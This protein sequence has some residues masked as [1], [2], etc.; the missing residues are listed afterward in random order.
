MLGDAVDAETA[1]RWGMIWQAVDDAA[2]GPEAEALA[3]RLAKAPAGAL[4]AIKT[5]FAASSGN[6]LFQQLDLEAR[7]QGEAG[8]SADFAEGVRAFQS[9]RPARFGG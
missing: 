4:A 6:T 1:E 3:V 8:R 7:L 5:M 9:K 2:L